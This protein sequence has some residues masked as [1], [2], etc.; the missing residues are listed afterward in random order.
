MS[1]NLK[2]RV[3][4]GLFWQ[5]FQRIGAQAVSFIVSIILARLLTPDDFG[6]IALIGVFITICNIFI[7]SGFGNAL[8]QRKSI[9][10]ID[11]SSVF[12]TNLGVS[13]IL[14]RSEEHTSE[15]QSR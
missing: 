3:L 11:T 13:L 8:I 10:E 1:N 6:T 2:T 5:Y 9:D 7:D 12:Y 4:K 14:Y 15:L